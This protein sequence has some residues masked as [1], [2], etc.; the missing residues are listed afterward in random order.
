MRNRLSPWGGGGLL[1]LALLATP[2]LL[3]AQPPQ[4]KLDGPGIQADKDH[5]AV[6]NTSMGRIV[7]QLFADQA[8]KTVQNF[9]NLAEGSKPWR[10]PK[11]GKTIKRR[12]Y[13]GLTFHRVIPG[14]MIQGGDPLG[15]G[16]GGP[17]FA[18]EDE[19]HP[20]L[21]FSRDYLLAMANAGP[22]TNGSQF[23]IT[24]RQSTPTHL[25]GRH[26]I[27]GRVVEGADVV[28]QIAAAPRNDTDKPL[29][30]VVLQYVQII[31]LD[32]GTPTQD[33]PWTALIQ[34]PPQHILEKSIAK[35]P[36]ANPAVDIKFQAPIERQSP[37]S[38]EKKTRP[39]ELRKI[40]PTTPPQALE[41]RAGS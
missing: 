3:H 34:A 20:D 32:K 38:G 23:F 6:L 1:I 16:R 35:D 36:S 25:N 10:E 26:T 11:S 9:V 8:P 2:L 4:E 41:K 17:G 39:K 40:T 29:E 37:Q 13:D 7:V 19:I 21:H 28:D 27:F 14:F 30:D 22:G 18:F 5:Y 15:N 31:R 24:T 12:F 33:A